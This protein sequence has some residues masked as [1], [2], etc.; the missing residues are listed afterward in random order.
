LEQKA[1]QRLFIFVP[2]FSGDLRVLQGILTP[3]KFIMC[4]MVREV[5]AM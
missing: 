5:K 4:L 3:M 2:D 1:I